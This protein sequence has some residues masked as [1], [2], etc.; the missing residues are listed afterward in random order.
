MSGLSLRPSFS[1]EL[2]F[3]VETA[4]QRIMTQVES[5]AS[6]CELKSF[7]GFICL[8]IP[9]ADRHFWSP[10]L[11]ISLEE[12]ETGHTQVHGMFGPNAN[13]WSSY[14]YGYLIIG[15]VGIFSGI[16]GGCQWMLK[17]SAWG[18]WVL[19]AML[20]IAAGMLLAAQIG[21]RLAAS[22]MTQLHRIYESAV[23]QEVEIG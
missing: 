3:D 18:L 22:Q 12:T 21:Q 17:Q 15:S 13:M 2:E 23:G 14:L 6:K 10:R 4:R 9:L 16:L 8:R 19:G 11:N 7:P 20:V 1:H 5:D